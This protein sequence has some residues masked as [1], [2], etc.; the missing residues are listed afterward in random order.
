[1]QSTLEYLF[2]K[3]DLSGVR[4]EVSGMATRPDVIAAFVVDEAGVIVAASRYATIG[5]AASAMLPEIP[6][7]LRA[8]TQPGWRPRKPGFR[9]A[10]S[11]RAIETSWSPIIPC[12]SPQT[13]RLACRALAAR[14]Y[15]SPP[16]NLAKGVRSMRPA[17]K[18]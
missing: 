10:S 18:P 5:S 9:G 12:W 3:E 16:C 6:E 13:A 2:R 7:D 17:A 11:W 14:W 4:V 15:S 8:I 1:L